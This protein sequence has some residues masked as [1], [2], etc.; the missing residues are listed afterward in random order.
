MVKSSAWNNNKDISQTIPA[1]GNDSSNFNWRAFLR[2]EYFCIPLNLKPSTMN[3]SIG[4]ISIFAFD[5]M[6][7]LKT[8]ILQGHATTVTWFEYQRDPGAIDLMSLSQE[9]QPL[10]Q[11]EI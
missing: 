2:F 1:I 6:H 9:T 11:T 5:E 10:Y 8:V 3:V 7:I 4:F